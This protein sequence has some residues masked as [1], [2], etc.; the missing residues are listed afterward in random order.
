MTSEKQISSFQRLISSDKPV[1][2]D[3][4]ATWCGPCHAFAPILKQLKEEAGDAIRI[5][6]IDVDRNQAL[7]QKLGVK[8]MPTVM[9]YQNGTLKW[10]AAGVQTLDTLKAR[11]GL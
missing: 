10:Q 3:F 7:C 6:K 1:L 2:I 8:S 9:I 11:L 5:I 4:H